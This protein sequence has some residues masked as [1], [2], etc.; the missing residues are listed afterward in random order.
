MPA[1]LTVSAGF[2]RGL[3]EVAVARGAERSELLARARIERAALD[4]TDRRLPFSTYVALMRAGQTLAGDPALALHFGEA[5][6]IAQ[7]SIVGLIG[8]AAATVLEAFHQLNRYVPLIVETDNADGGPRFSLRPAPGGVWVIDNRLHADA[9]PEL[10]ES[11]LAQLVCGPRRLGISPPVKRV[12]VTHADPGYA[13]EYERI[14]QAP[15]SFGADCNG[16]L[17]AVSTVELPVA[18][19]P[20]YAFGV[21]TDRADALLAELER[22]RSVRAQVESLLLPVLHTGDASAQQVA[23]RLGLSRQTLF[24]RLKAEGATFAGVLDGLRH[25]M[26]LHYLGGR[27]VSVNETAYLVGFSD[28]AAFSR[29]FKRWTGLSPSAMR[30]AAE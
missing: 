17:Y 10:T 24:R 2:A 30:T 20:R 12:C 16:V 15:A 28:P 21:L 23:G 27:R 6:A 7:V 22:G 19:L 14:F 8:E 3:A 26:A 4:D 18:R 29:A 5:G 9:F 1:E 25:K 13:G 11:A